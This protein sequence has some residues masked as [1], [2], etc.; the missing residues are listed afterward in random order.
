MVAGVK[1]DLDPVALVAMLPSSFIVPAGGTGGPKE[2][3][4]DGGGF[5]DI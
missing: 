5:I 3:P 2:L 4:G 1:F